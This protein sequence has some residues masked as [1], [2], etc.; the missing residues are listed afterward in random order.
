M[1]KLLA[2]LAV[3][4]CLLGVTA[5]AQYFPEPRNNQNS[6]KVVVLT[7]FPDACAHELARAFTA[8][9][10][11]E[12]E[13]ILD[14]TTKILARLRIEKRSPRGDVWF[15]GGG[16]IPFMTAAEED[17]LAPY[18]P[19][20]IKDMP[21]YRGSLTMRDPQWRWS[22]L[23]VVSQG[24][25]Y[26]P[27]VLKPS[28]IPKTWD[29]LADPKWQGQIEMWDPSDSGTSMLFLA[30]TLQRYIKRNGDE[31]AGWEYLKKIFH[32]LKRYTREGKPAFSVA[33]GDTRIG[34]HFENQYLEFLDQQRG[35]KQLDQVQANIAWYLPPES[36]V[37]ADG[38]ALIKGC[39]HPENGR[40]F[41]D[42]C[43]SHEG[44]K[45]INRYFFSIDPDLP[46][47][48]GLMGI[49]FET[50]MD[51]AQELDLPWMSANYDRIRKQ[52]QNEV[53][54]GAEQ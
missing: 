29:E 6:N 51:R 53:E 31:K 47:P 26:N 9:T 42:F 22:P 5:C 43:L 2:C 45:I 15:S 44:Q 19:P 33:R 36:T 14:S 4:I 16:C 30:G 20:P 28:E 23:A 11:I 18:A 39:P 48:Q 7:P 54:A 38:I 12:V 46:P 49:T 52:W 8:K 21:I 25:C 32:N 3:F 50:L 34:L 35:D 27:Q 17:L 1:R 10:G 40:K 37:L 13:E 24:F 41:I